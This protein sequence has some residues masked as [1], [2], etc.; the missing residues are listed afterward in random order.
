LAWT[1]PRLLAITSGAVRISAGVHLRAEIGHGR[2]LISASAPYALR[3]CSNLRLMPVLSLSLRCCIRLISAGQCLIATH[4]Y[5]PYKTRNALTLAGGRCA[6][7]VVVESI[8]CLRPSD[9]IGIEVAPCQ[10]T[11]PGRWRD[12]ENALGPPHRPNHREGRIIQQQRLETLTPTT[13]LA[14]KLPWKR[15]VHSGVTIA[16]SS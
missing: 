15:K 16:T 10:D 8:E 6:R 9:R 13:S 14:V 7:Q 12:L 5:L 2:A 3:G 11:A 4:G 1:D